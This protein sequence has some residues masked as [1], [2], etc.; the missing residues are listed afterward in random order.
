MKQPRV[1]VLRA[2]GIKRDR[3]AAAAD[4]QPR[5]TRADP[6]Q[7]GSWRGDVQMGDYLL[8]FFY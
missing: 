3:N 5:L 2:P 6:Y 4:E 1:L 8:L 7:S